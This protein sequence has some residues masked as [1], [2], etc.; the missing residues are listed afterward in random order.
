[1][2]ESLKQYD[3]FLNAKLYLIEHKVSDVLHGN[4]LKEDYK[5]ALEDIRSICY[6]SYE[7]VIEKF[8]F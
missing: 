7:Q 1:M 4:A 3:K 2:K 6:A 8:N 5:K